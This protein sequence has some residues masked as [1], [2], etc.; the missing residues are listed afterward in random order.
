MIFVRHT[1]VEVSVIKPP[2]RRTSMNSTVN[3]DSQVVLKVANVHVDAVVLLKD[4]YTFTSAWDASP[5]HRST[6]IHITPDT[7][8]CVV[9][10]HKNICA[11][12]SHNTLNVTHR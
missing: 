1:V 8:A 9:P 12:Y 2:S 4:T 3:N 10:T 5:S 7:S 11:T 6:P